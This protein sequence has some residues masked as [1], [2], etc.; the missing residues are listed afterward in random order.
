MTEGQEG[1]IFDLA[2][3]GAGPAGMSA[4]ALAGEIGLSTVVLDEQ[5]A[6]GGQ[7]YR[8]IEHA[9]GTRLLGESYLKGAALADAFRATA[10]DYRPGTGVWHVETDAG[11]P[12]RLWLLR[13]GRVGQIRA[14]RVLLA[15]GAIERP[16][17]VPGWTL[18]GVMT[19]GAL[20]ILLKSSGIVPDGPVVLVGNGPLL[21]LTAVQLAAAGAQVAAVLVT[22][23]RSD[24][25]AARRHL[26]GFLASG[27]WRAGLSLLRDF[28][29]LGLRVVRNVAEVAV[30][31][32]D[33]ARGV[34]YRTDDGQSGEIAAG[35]VT[36]HEGVVPASSL[37]RAIGCD[38][39]W[40]AE[41]VTFRPRLDDWG[42]STIE[43]VQ[44]AGDGA[45]IMGADA[46]PLTGRIAV[47]EAARA[48][49]RL[50]T[51]E[52]DRRAAPL[53]RRLGRI[54]RGRP[55]IDRL[56]APRL[57]RNELPDPVVVCRCEEVTA[58]AIRAAVASGANGPNQIK[59]FL[60]CGMGPCQ[61][62][63]CALTVT[64]LIAEARGVTEGEVGT[65]RLRPPVKP[66][67]LGAFA[68]AMEE[69][70]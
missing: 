29:A 21:Y 41:Q 56:Y 27:T 50:T 15:G 60:R 67:A 5:P 10:L 19:V 12:C 28:R 70:P 49:G 36:L 47:L 4:A 58:G 30:E 17:P 64:R 31:G 62:R 26:T 7:I 68:A 61:G 37:A 11:E 53:R 18:P 16:V 20:Q 13:D 55:F 59:A 44:I 65:F 32:E 39:D 40:D 9:G 35:I 43:A 24:G 69:R 3:V 33:C 45:G 1:P 42:R 2:I 52:R 54:L 66:V 8:N 22:G 23:A 63:F 14:R 57:A 51:A 46:A 38:Q 48:L 6:P 34:R 25:P